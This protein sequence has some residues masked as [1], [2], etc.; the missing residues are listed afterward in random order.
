MSYRL[1]HNTTVE[2]NL[3]RIVQ[4]QID[5]AI[6]EMTTQQLE[7]HEVI[8]QV[9]KRCKKIRGILRLFRSG[10]GSTYP[11][12]NVFFRDAARLLSELRDAQ[13]TIETYDQ[14]METFAQQV[15]R[16]TFAP[17]RRALTLRRERLATEI[18]LE[19]RLAEFLSRLHD[20]RSRVGRWSLSSEGLE[21]IAAGLAKT[22]RR[23]CKA[24][25]LADES[26]ADR[27]L[28]TWRKRVKYHWYHARLLSPIWP[29]VMAAYIDEVKRLS[30]FLG[31][32]HNLAVLH[33]LLLATADEFSNVQTVQTLVGLIEQHRGQLQVEAMVL[34]KRILAEKPTRLTHRW[35]RYWQIWQ[36]DPARQHDA[37]EVVLSQS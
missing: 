5:R 37:V 16:Q 31:D 17:I 9:R 6:R 36:V 28:H 15:E 7:R 23:A 13:A 22:Y 11:F 25:R 4:E 18:G 29:P 14:L 26:L 30:D 21:P 35:H 32:D 2:K 27:S 33:R 10:L 1:Q 3:K 34:G 8:H 12:E 24:M 19:E 20:A